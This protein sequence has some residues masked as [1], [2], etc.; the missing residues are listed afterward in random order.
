MTGKFVVTSQQLLVR[1]LR[2]VIPAL[3]GMVLKDPHHPVVTLMSVLTQL[4]MIV[5]SLLELLAQMPFLDLHV[6]VMLGML[7][8]EVFVLVSSENNDNFT[9]CTFL[10]KKS[11]KNI[12]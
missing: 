4:L 7:E 8:M 1:I 11:C 3:A 5:T 9:F 6:L 10:N 2:V 12:F